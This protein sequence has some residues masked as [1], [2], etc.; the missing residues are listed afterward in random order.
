VRQTSIAHGAFLCDIAGFWFAF[1]SCL[2]F[3][4]FRADPQLGTAFRLAAGFVWLVIV[5]GY[6]VLSPAS[7]HERRQYN[8]SLRWIVI[9]LA[10]AGF[11][12]LWTSSSSPAIAAGYWAGLVA[13]VFAVYLLLRQPPVEDNARRMMRGFIVGALALAI[14][15]WIA[16]ATDD[17]R[18]G[19]EE[20]LHP[21]L[22]GF[23]FA[24]GALAAAHLAPKQKLWSAPAIALGVTTI[25][26]LSKGAIV[27]FLVAGLYCLMRGSKI[28]RKAR[29]WIGIL[30]TL[31]LVSFWGLAE[32]YFNLYATGN[33]VETLTGRTYIWSQTIE[34]F[35]EK[36]WL[37]YGFDSFRW[38]FPAFADFL[39][40]HA[41]NEFFQ[42]LF[43]YGLVGILVVISVYWS[44]YR[45]VRASER[46]G[47]RSLA[48]AILILVLVRGIVDTDQFGL[49]F[50]LWLMT[51]FA[52][53]LVP[54]GSS[55]TV[56][57]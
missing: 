36:P 31:V 16:P 48:M 21:N 5:V 35:L 53:A 40:N 7:R 42:Q 11:S 41:H 55:R 54:A 37:G 47:L 28:S 6:A 10:L 43:T 51:M 26:T 45:H 15:A 34:L 56:P 19:N 27:A 29:V 24:I 39:P 32:A 23:Y 9:Y 2:T 50:P 46:S 30:S 22:I 52:M 4:F 13:E 44:F 14:V 38:T 25:R 17:L 18:L 57:S 49:C 3:L 20:F 33:N 12:I 1:K 8:A